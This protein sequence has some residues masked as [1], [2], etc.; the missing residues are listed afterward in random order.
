MEYT[1][2]WWKS[3]N[4]YHFAGGWSPSGQQFAIALE[5]RAFP[6]GKTARAAEAAAPVRASLSD[7]ARLDASDIH[8]EL[9]F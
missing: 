7:A 6:S 3:S 2:R 5:Q 9:E 4:F 8:I 1:L